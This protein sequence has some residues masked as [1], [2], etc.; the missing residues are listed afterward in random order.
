MLKNFVAK[1]TA[2]TDVTVCTAAEGKELSIMS[3]MINGGANGG[4]ITLKY[5]NGFTAGFT[6]AAEDTIFIDTKVNL[7][8]DT[9]LAINAT[10]AGIS[11]MASAAE[12]DA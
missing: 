5:P 7:P 10:A 6:I 3:V 4:D 12:L 9:S 11:V 1:S 2:N 8:P